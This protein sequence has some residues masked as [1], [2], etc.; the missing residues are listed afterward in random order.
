MGAI[1]IDG[2][3]IAAKQR[4]EVREQAGRLKE[5][6]IYPCLAVILVGDDPSR[7]FPWK[8]KPSKVSTTTAPT[9]SRSIPD[10]V[11]A[12]IPPYSSKRLCFCQSPKIVISTR[13]LAAIPAGVAL[14]ATG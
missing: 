4:E 10:T 2:K 9:P 3:A 6:G 13:L 8:P 14:L 1:V 7:A 12:K 5:Q 11:I